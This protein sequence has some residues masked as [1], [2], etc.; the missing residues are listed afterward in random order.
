M[1]RGSYCRIKISRQA[2]TEREWRRRAK[3][4]RADI[5]AADAVWSE[6]VSGFAET[7]KDIA[8]ARLR[9]P[10]ERECPDWNMSMPPGS[11]T[12]AFQSIFSLRPCTSSTIVPRRFDR[13]ANRPCLIREFVYGRLSLSEFT[14][15]MLRKS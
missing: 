13:D 5:L 15:T 2:G 1:G 12:I 10:T 4:A 14:V 9:R 7:A 6:A 11:R 8:N 3:T